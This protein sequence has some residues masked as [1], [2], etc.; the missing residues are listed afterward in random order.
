MAKVQRRIAIELTRQEKEFLDKLLSSLYN[1]ND[2]NDVIAEIFFDIYNSSCPRADEKCKQ[3]IG[4]CAD[5]TIT[6]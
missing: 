5:I 2:E 4:A 3:W 6:N 1:I